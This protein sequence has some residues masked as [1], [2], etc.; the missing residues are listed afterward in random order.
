MTFAERVWS[1]LRN[2]N[3]LDRVKSIFSNEERDLEEL[4]KMFEK[5]KP[6][7]QG[8][9]V[10]WKYTFRPIYSRFV[11]EKCVKDPKRIHRL[12]AVKQHCSYEDC[13]A[14]E[15]R[16]RNNSLWLSERDDEKGAELLRNYFKERATDSKEKDIAKYLDRIAYISKE[17]VIVYED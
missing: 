17:R 5:P 12:L 6:W 14:Y 3:S 8:R 4:S 1:T 10:V 7:Y 9:E 16:V 2:T 11:V 13:S 15:G